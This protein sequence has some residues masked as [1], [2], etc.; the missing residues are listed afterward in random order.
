MDPR[1]EG[2]AAF[3]NLSDL[4]EKCY[5]LGFCITLNTF[6]TDSLEYFFYYFDY[7][8]AIRRYRIMRVNKCCM[9]RLNAWVKHHLKL[10]PKSLFSF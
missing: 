9:W 2:N 8:V 4:R 5:A 1:I 6:E 3:I 10:K 7:V